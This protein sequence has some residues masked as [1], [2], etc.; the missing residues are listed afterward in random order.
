M[1]ASRKILIT[2]G[3]LLSLWGMSYG[4]Y[5]AVFVEHQTLDTIGGALA[6]SFAG[7]SQRKMEAARVNLESYAVTSFDYVRQVDAHSHWIGLGILLIGLGIIF[8]WV[9]FGERF[10]SLLALTLFI[11]S[12][13]FP[14]GVILQTMKYGSAPIVI[15]AAGAGLV[16]AALAVVALGFMR[17][18]KR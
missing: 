6:A 17:T 12:S 1:T 4:L 14:F 18:E 7:A 2:G 3:L 10:R 9:S 8:D 11:G 15:A 16:T 13:V 5:Y